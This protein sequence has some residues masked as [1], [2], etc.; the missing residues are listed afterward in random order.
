M[1]G[2]TLSVVVKEVSTGKATVSYE[3]ER[4]V[5]PASVL[6]TVS[7]A[8]ALD[9]LGEAYRYTTTLE[10]D[11][12]IEAGVL[13]GNI[14]IKGSGDPSLGSSHFEE[15]DFMEEW[16]AAIKQAGIQQISGAIVADESIFDVEGISSKWLR[17]D[18]G[19]YYAPGSYGLSVFDNQY[20]LKLQTNAV[21]TRPKV[22]GTEPTI[23]SLRFINYLKAAAVSS[24]S[25]YIFGAPFANERY[26][27]GVVPANRQ[28]Y[29]LKGD[30]PDPALFLA[31]YLT[32]RLEQ[33]GIVI[34][35]EPTCYRIE[36]EAGRWRTV[37]R[38]VIVTTYSPTL[39]E[40][41]NIT[42]HTSHNLF[43]DALLKT[44]GLQ[45]KPQRNEVISS[46]GKG[47]QVVLNHWEKKG[48]DVSSLKLYDGSGVAPTDRVTADFITDM[49]VYMVTRSAASKSY[50][51]S[52]PQAGVE[53][54]VR[55]FLKGSRLQGK[56]F[57]KSGSM[58]GVRCFAGYIEKE[59]KL[60]AVALFSN[61][62][63]CKMSQMNKGL[64][65]LLLQLF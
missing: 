31:T 19:N 15:H 55:S 64:E 25:A 16:I 27:Y 9:M 40:I 6:K 22:I 4:A 29:I 2:A 20:K 5:I 60:Y 56:A 48:L 7:T 32:E 24:D 12:K 38:K 35:K 52:F 26:L 46:F 3:S 63:T 17:E 36:T 65:Q 11:G 10:H 61:N 37:P 1:K 57:L 43:A 18:M 42:N 62:Y 47:V 34:G 45:Y 8:T 21:S 28:Q 13:T 23:S 39:G 51:D 54:S 50:M 59:G 58:T 30:I 49:L 14:Y 44:V 41:A 53:G 33:E